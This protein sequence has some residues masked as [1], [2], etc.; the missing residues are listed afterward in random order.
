MKGFEDREELNRRRD[1]N[2]AVLI[3]AAIF[4]KRMPKF[5]QSK[6]TKKTKMTDDEMF[7]AVQ[8]LNRMMGGTEC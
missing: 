7:K 5:E 8:A 2:R 6:R 1:Y 3:R 4:M